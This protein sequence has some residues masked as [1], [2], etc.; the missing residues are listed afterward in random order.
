MGLRIHVFLTLNSINGF[1]IRSV[2]TAVSKYICFISTKDFEYFHKFI[3]LLF[4][5]RFECSKNVYSLF[6][7]L[8]FQ[9]SHIGIMYFSYLATKNVQ[10]VIQYWLAVS[11]LDIQS[12]SSRTWHLTRLI[13]QSV[14]STK[15]PMLLPNA[16]FLY[17][18]GPFPS[19]G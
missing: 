17:F 10:P 18:F 5:F 7:L 12:I 16:L 4:Y 8:Y 11:S 19:L 13:G 14:V 9:F 6:G 2:W 3:E 1:S 15:L